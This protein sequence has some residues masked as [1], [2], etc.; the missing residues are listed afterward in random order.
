MFTQAEL[1]DAVN[2][3]TSGKHSI[4][5]CEKL[6]AVYTVLDHLYGEKPL[7]DMGYS[8]DNRIES[9]VGLYG[10]SKFLEAIVGKSS[11]D[12]WL[13]MDE[14]IEAITILNPRLMNNFFEKLNNL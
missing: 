8:N 10:N 14:L 3:L 7:I 2:E 11:K 6:A 5:N 4:Q 12:A 9:E 1:E 13:L